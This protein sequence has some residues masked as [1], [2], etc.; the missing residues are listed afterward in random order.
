MSRLLEKLAIC[1]AAA[2]V[3]LAGVL[4]LL[5]ALWPLWLSIGALALTGHFIGWW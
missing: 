4:I 2:G 5:A 3:C 1:L